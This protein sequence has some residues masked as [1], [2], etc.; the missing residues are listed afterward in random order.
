MTALRKYLTVHAPL[1]F[2][3]CSLTSAAEKQ[4]PLLLPWVRM[5]VP[6]PLST[7]NRSCSERTWDRGRHVLRRW[8]E[9]KSRARGQLPFLPIGESSTNPPSSA[10]L[11]AIVMGAKQGKFGIH[12]LSRVLTQSLNQEYPSS[13]KL[14]GISWPPLWLDPEYGFYSVVQEKW[15]PHYPW[16][17]A[18]SFIILAKLPYK[19]NLKQHPH[20]THNSRLLW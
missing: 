7:S 11:T 2:T 10:M 14:R 13:G 4:K 8:S 5:K 9:L 16:A 19:Y 6:A 20:R 18:P 12:G 15:L 3:A 1:A 17:M